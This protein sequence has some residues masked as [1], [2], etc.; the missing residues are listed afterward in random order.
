MANSKSGLRAALF[1]VL[2][3]NVS[4]IMNPFRIN[5]PPL[6]GRLKDMSNKSL[7][8]GRMLTNMGEPFPMFWDASP[9]IGEPVP[10]FGD[11]SPNVERTFLKIGEPF[12]MFGDA[13]PNSGGAISG[14]AC[15]VVPA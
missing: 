9:K 1:G 5:L 15:G 4:S 7:D 13:F 3:V 2:T 14:L 11:D 12:P 6:Y 8:L 10:M